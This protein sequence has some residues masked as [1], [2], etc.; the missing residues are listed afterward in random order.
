MLRNKKQAFPAAL[1]E[2]ILRRCCSF[3]ECANGSTIQCIHSF[4]RGSHDGLGCLPNS[5]WWNCDLV[6]GSIFVTVMRFTELIINVFF[7]NFLRILQCDLIY[8]RYV[9]PHPADL[10][11]VFRRGRGEFR[12][13]CWTKGIPTMTLLSPNWN[14]QITTRPR[15][16]AV[17]KPDEKSPWRQ[18]NG[19][20]VA[21]RSPHHRSDGVYQDRGHNKVKVKRRA[22]GCSSNKIR[23][24]L[25]GTKVTAQP[26]THGHQLFEKEFSNLDLDSTTFNFISVFSYAI[27]LGLL[28]R[29]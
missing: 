19:V 6:K 26:H 24:K 1:F 16:G 18:Q 10:F 11:V 27:L 8:P 7:R 21:Y 22:W 23:H 25:C 2:R 29:N 3:V 9:A 15:E 17:K 13:L 12:D 4:R 20:L 14:K 5:C 28:S